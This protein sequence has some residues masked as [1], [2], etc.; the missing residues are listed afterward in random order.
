LAE[1]LL[2][3]YTNEIGQVIITPSSGGVFEVVVNDKLVFSKKELN[4]FPE[5]IEIFKALEEAF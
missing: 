3:N 5:A 4:R 1:A 2:K